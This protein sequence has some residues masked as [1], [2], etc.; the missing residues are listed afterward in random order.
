[1]SRTDIR[2][3]VYTG[4]NSVLNKVLA[5]FKSIDGL[6]VSNKFLHPTDGH[7]NL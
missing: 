1:M 2:E 4:E 3:F 6:A 7:P 5:I